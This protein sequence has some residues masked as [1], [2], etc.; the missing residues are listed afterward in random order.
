MNG[1]VRQKPQTPRQSYRRHPLLQTELVTSSCMPFH[2]RE[3]VPGRTANPRSGVA[4]RAE[5]R[6]CPFFFRYNES[7]HHGHLLVSKDSWPAALS[8][9]LA[10]GLSSDLA[11]G[12]S[13]D[14]ASGLSS[15]LASGLSSDL[16]SGLSSDLASG[17]SSD[18]ASGLS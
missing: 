12:L 2:I 9:D 8:S 6:S 3:P 13:S 4:A 1:L 5:G 16:A 10:S 15:D 17:L 14:L 7:S 18:L 11:S